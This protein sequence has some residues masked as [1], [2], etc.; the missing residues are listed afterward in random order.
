MAFL[1]LAQ[2]ERPIAIDVVLVR[3]IAVGSL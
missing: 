2:I 3:P 1:S